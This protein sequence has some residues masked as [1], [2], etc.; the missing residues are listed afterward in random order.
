MFSEHKPS[1]ILLL[2]TSFF[3]QTIQVTNKSK[4]FSS[5]G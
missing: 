1:S 4:E 2:K 5:D 3:S